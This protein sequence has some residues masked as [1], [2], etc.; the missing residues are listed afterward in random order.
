[1]NFLEKDLEDIICKTD[2]QKLYE[3]GL[4]ING[5]K[6]RQV[7]IGN[8]G[9]CDLITYDRTHPFALTITIYEL[10]KDEVNE[11]TFSQVIKYLTG[12]K[13]YLS[14]RKPNLR[15]IYKIVL[16]GKT[17]NN[18]DSAAFLPSIFPSLDIYTYEY[19]YDG[20]YFVNKDNFI[21]REEGFNG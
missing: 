7:R 4:Y 11:K 1:M 6:L 17:L 2:N 14:R 3:R 8:Y 5:K 21:L 20:I 9:I 16:V 13:S 12:I 18:Y 15:V 19:K 10:K